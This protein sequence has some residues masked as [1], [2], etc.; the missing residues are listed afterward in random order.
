MYEKLGD[1]Q[2]L[3]WQEYVNTLAGQVFG[4]QADCVSLI[5]VRLKSLS[6]MNLA[7]FP[8]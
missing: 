5:S 4:Q 8:Q 6:Q 7:V 3:H 1:T 2:V